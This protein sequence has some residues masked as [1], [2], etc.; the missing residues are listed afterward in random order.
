[1]SVHLGLMK[2][3]TLVEK[4]TDDLGTGDQGAWEAEVGVPRKVDD[5]KLGKLTVRGEAYDLTLG[6]DEN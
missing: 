3:I 4:E 5:R 1:V 2:M 6:I